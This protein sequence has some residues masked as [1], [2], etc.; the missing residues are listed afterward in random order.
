MSEI[1]FVDTTVLLNLLRVPGNFTDDVA[2]ADERELAR[3][4]DAGGQ[5]VLPVTTVIETGNAV[6]QVSGDR[7]R[8]IE[9]YLAV[10]RGAVSPNPPWIAAGF[11]NVSLI[12]RLLEDEPN[13][14]EDLMTAGVGAGDAA[15]LAEIR[16]LRGRVPSA[17][18]I[19]IW[20][21]DV[22]LSA[23]G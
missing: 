9:R 16:E 15:I 3:I 1:V 14:L 13:R 7:H 11:T 19:R 2:E 5:L 10:L 12:V 23:Y 22:G 21:H 6:A 17:T 4:V 18:P 20:T 8:C